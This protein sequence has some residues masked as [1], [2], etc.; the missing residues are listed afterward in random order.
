MAYT[1]QF[2]AGGNDKRDRVLAYLRERLVKDGR[3]SATFEVG[4][5]RVTRS[6]RIDHP[7]LVVGNY[8]PTILVRKVR[9]TKKKAY[10][11]NHPGECPVSDKPKPV[12]SRLEWDDWVAFHAIVNKALNRFRAD[13]NVWS[14]PFDVRGRM[15]IRRGKSPRVRYDWTE[16][17]DR[18]GRMIRIWNPGSFDQFQKEAA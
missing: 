15:W 1:I 14:L 8:L 17:M 6:D 2:M 7:Q 11:G 10:C 4:S 16:Q 3:F 13:A 9:L 18:Y 12:S 5:E